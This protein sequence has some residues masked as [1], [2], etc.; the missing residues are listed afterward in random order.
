VREIN[1]EKENEREMERKIEWV[2]K[3]KAGGEGRERDRW[4]FGHAG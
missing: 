2:R 3:R 4:L 1:R